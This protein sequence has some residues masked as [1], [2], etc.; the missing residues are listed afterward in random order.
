MEVRRGVPLMPLASL[1]DD[2]EWKGEGAPGGG[3]G[4]GEG[5]CPINDCIVNS[6]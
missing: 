6:C 2:V 5:I 4:V 3:F 1:E